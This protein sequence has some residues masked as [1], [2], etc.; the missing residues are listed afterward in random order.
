MSKSRKLAALLLAAIV[1]CGGSWQAKA[2][3]PSNYYIEDPRTFYG[4]LILGGNFTQVDGDAFAGYHKLGLNA[5]GIIYMHIAPNLAASMELLFSQKGARAHKPQEGGAGNLIT[6]YRIDLNYAEIP[7]QLNYFDKRKSHF[8]AGLSYSRLITAKES[9]ET[10]PPNQ[11]GSPTYVNLEDYPFQKSDIN[12]ILGG[13]LK[14]WQGLF[15]NI[16]FQYSMI[17]V[18]KNIPPG[19]GRA[20]QFNNMWTVRFMYLF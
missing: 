18:R 1:W 11:M 8:G 9:L 4:G 2:Q 5:G 15:L 3:N 20:E 19:Y 12:F 10:N 7:I 17:S 6:Q 14:L 13:N 16:R